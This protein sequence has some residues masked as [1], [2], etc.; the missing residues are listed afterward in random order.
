MINCSDRGK[1]ESLWAQ[2]PMQYGTGQVPKTSVRGSG[3]CRQGFVFFVFLGIG[4][5][6]SLSCFLGLCAKRR[7]ETEMSKNVGADKQNELVANWIMANCHEEI[8]D[9]GAGDVAV[10]LLEKYRGALLGVM[11]ELGIPG[12]G[13]PMPV[14]NAYELAQNALMPNPMM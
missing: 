11:S 13:Y 2:S 4:M 7:K 3:L 8:G 5:C 10:R 6:L 12:E 1:G 9:E 14:A